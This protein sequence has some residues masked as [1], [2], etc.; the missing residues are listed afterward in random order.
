MLRRS[1]ELEPNFALTH[2][3][4]SLVLGLGKRV[5]LLEDSQAIVDEAVRH[6]EMAMDLDELDS[7]VVGLAGCALSDVGFVDRAIPV[8]QNAIDLNPRNGQA[9]AALGTSY[10]VQGRFEEADASL[11]KGIELSPA[12]GRLAVW[13]A[14]RSLVQ[15]QRG[16]IDDAVES[17][18]L[19]TRSDRKSY[20]PWVVLAAARLAQGE[21]Q[22]AHAALDQA[23]RT[24]SDLSL[25]EIGS[26]VGRKLTV[27]IRKALRSR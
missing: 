22:Q 21:S 17:A 8:L 2:A 16:M 18:L 6:A 13:Y 19:G 14:T 10:L 7:N 11:N 1:I 26:L 23:Y 4:L 15:L 24:K 12:D 3:S 27:L 5:G 9:H 20:L 25:D